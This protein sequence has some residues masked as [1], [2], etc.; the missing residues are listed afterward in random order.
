MTTIR[1]ATSFILSGERVLLLRRSAK[2]RSMPG[3]WAGVSGVIEGNERPL[4]RARTEIL[5]EIGM[6][7]GGVTLLK[8]G[9]TVLAGSSRYP[10]CTWQIHP[11]LF[12]VARP[13]VILNWENSEFRWV[14]RS[15]LSGYETVPCLEAILS[16]LL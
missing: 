14:R 9:P 1:A 4:D 5:E 16:C 10:G 7:P 11:F 15:E 6:R 13:E 12:R 8:E 2:M 3:M